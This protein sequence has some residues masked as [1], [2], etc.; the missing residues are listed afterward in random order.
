MQIFGKVSSCKGDG[1]TGGPPQFSQCCFAAAPV[2]AAQYLHNVHSQTVQIDSGMKLRGLC[3]AW[4]CALFREIVE[5][6]WDK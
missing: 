3:N 6:L 5:V 1:F 2:P 4:S